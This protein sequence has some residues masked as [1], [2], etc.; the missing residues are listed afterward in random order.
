MVSRLQRQHY[1]TGET[2]QDAFAKT[3]T[4]GFDD[5]PSPET[6]PAE[7]FDLLLKHLNLGHSWVGGKSRYSGITD[8]DRYGYY[9]HVSCKDRHFFITKNGYFGLGPLFC[10]RGDRIVWFDGGST[11]LII[12]K[13]KRGCYTLVG[14]AYIRG[15]MDFKPSKSDYKEIRLV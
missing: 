7:L 8:L 1:V 15:R 5:P 3:L 12:R 9:V 11:P 14:E 13:A 4:T 2:L 6:A 10:R